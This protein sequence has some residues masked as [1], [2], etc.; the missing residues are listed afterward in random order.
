LATEKFFTC[1]FRKCYESASKSRSKE[2]IV[3]T[4]AYI[5]SALALMLAACGS[6]NTVIQP[7]AHP[8][9]DAS[10]TNNQP[11]AMDQSQPDAAEQPVPDAAEQPDAPVV[12]HPDAMPHPDAVP[13]P[14]A[15][16]NPQPDAPLGGPD[17][18]PGACTADSTY[19]D[20][21]PQSTAISWQ[22]MGNTT[23]V[24]FQQY[25]GLLTSTGTGQDALDIEFYPGY[26]V[27][28]AGMPTTGTFDLSGEGDYS[29]C[30][31]CVLILTDLDSMGAPTDIYMPV[32]GSG[33]VSSFADWTTGQ[34]TISGTLTNMM[35]Q[36]V[37]IASDLT[38]T[39]VSDGC[40]VS[41]PTITFTATAMVMQE[42][43]RPVSQQTRYKV[44]KMTIGNGK[45]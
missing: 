3:K 35:M 7:D 5:T 26:G 10:T 14:D 4:T 15:P 36:H 23:T 25:Q 45:K 1:R 17:G 41:M 20:N 22:P 16:S 34:G 37:T 24:D 13:Q 44:T 8:H 42:T 30:G 27:F 11:D 29:S 2:K 12:V 9:I 28:M 39:P 43:M 31:F 38:T 19:P 21:I 33:M 40:M 6:S 32:S 18:A